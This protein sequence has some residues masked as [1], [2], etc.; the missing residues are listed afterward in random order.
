MLAVKSF[1][2]ILSEFL[3]TFIIL[4]FSSLWWR[5]KARERERES[6][7]LVGSVH[8][9]GFWHVYWVW[10]EF[11]AHEDVF[12]KVSLS[13]PLLYIVTLR[14]KNDRKIVTDNWS[15]VQ[16]KIWSLVACTRLYNLICP[17]ISWSVGQ[18]VGRFL[19]NALLFWRLWADNITPQPKYN[20]KDESLRSS[21]W[22]L[23]RTLHHH[24]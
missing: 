20:N 5:E 24:P 17:S 22:G 2:M 8:A 21:Y 19:G 10:R 1:P 3:L 15:K 6:A 23:L 11:D 4:F 18:S 7:R 9:L 16:M 14:E 12:F 13:L